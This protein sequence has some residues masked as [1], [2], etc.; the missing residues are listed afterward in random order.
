MSR[1]RYDRSGSIQPLWSPSGFGALQG[2]ELRFHG[3]SL[4]NTIHA[5]CHHSSSLHHNYSSFHK[6]S[7][8][9]ILVKVMKPAD[10]HTDIWGA[11]CNNHTFVDKSNFVETE[12][13]LC[14]IWR[15]VTPCVTQKSYYPTKVT[16]VDKSTSLLTKV[17][18]VNKSMDVTNGALYR[19]DS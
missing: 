6:V 15:M 9:Q 12:V 18:S 17:A 5:G 13:L 4:R 2:N 19:H 11:V 1:S 14:Y 8:F 7:I 3:F 10:Q 16:F